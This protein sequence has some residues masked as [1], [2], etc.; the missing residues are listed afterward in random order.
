[1]CGIAGILHKDGSPIDAAM[2][3]RMTDAVVH[4]GPDGYGHWTDAG[5]GLGHRRLSIRDLSEN[6][7]QPMADDAGE[8]WVSYNGEI[9]NYGNL[10]REIE[11]VAGYHFRSDCDT[12]LLPIGWKLW[13]A[14][15]FDR[16]E[17]MF[18]IALWDRRTSQLVLARDGIGIK[19]LYVA[20]TQRA[21][22]F[23]SEIKALLATGALRRDINAAAFHTYLS[24]GYT[25][26]DESLLDGIHQVL[27]GSVVTIDRDGKAQSL[28]FWTP[29]REPRIADMGEALDGLHDVLGT[30]CA[31]MLAADV[32][33][34]LLQSSGVDSAL[35]AFSVRRDI[36]SFTATFEEVSH[37]EAHA[38]QRLA[39]LAGHPWH[40][41]PVDSHNDLADV[42]RHVALA[43]DG[44]LADSSCLAHYLL[45][46]AVRREVTV[47]LAGDGADEFFAGYPTYK[48]S[49]VAGMIAPV[50]PKRAA[51]FAANALA[52][53]YGA[54]E[55]RLP[56]HQVVG[57]FLQ[58]MA[59][60]A[61]THH[62]EW[63]RLA[64]PETLRDI[65]GAALR[66]MLD[67]DP[68]QGYRQPLRERGGNLLDRCLLADQTF[69]LPGDMLMKVDRMSM[70]H[71]LE[72][73]V[74]FLDRRMMDFAGQLDGN[75][76]ARRTGN[77]KRILRQSISAL[78]ADDEFV[79]GAKR[80]FN[81][82]LAKL[83][84]RDLKSVGDRLL[85]HMPDIFSPLLAP[86]ALR[87]LWRDHLDGRRN[88]AYLLW[89]LLI[90]GTWRE[91][92]L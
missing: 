89:A 18:A 46:G 83:L 14:Q 20:E 84:R 57:R 6:G 10:R 9:Y 17:G 42:F 56:W 44:Q 8:V 29:R 69:Y 77:G 21:I 52:G 82:P 32:P 26:P 68:M 45:S 73:R 74:P 86:D 3:K 35:L 16:L 36:P 87:R 63:R 92:N 1:M 72:I 64:A 34:G 50:V 58:G 5:I 76:L 67:H 53:R 12:E 27:P 43:V 51:S 37:N 15:L 70:A 33:V 65:A 91:A 38:A 13:G 81:V 25:A 2:L 80:G 62:A 22:Y 61:G 79:K 47:A 30:V 85:Q 28:R 11:H 55:S 7:H 4:R 19:P 48:A 49:R 88:H 24:I 59:A 71:S 78:G 39:A 66:P 40:P 75:L 60:P 23:G 31:E 90:F 54:D 41:V